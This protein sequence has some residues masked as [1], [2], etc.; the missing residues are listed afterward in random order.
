VLGKPKPEKPQK[1]LGQAVRRLRKEAELS[2]RALAER[3]GRSPSWISRIERGDCDPS[4]GDMRR[5]ARA[6]DVSLERLAEVAE[7][8]EGSQRDT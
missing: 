4:W 2:Q 8:H 6:L 3:M 7:E 1:G 5:L